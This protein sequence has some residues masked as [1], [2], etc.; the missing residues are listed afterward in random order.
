MVRAVT[1]LVVG[2]LVVSLVADV[3]SQLR[4]EGTLVSPT[5]DV[6]PDG[7]YWV[8]FAVYDSEDDSGRP[9]VVESQAVDLSGGSCC[10][11]LAA[12]ANGALDGGAYQV[13]PLQVLP[14]AEAAGGCSDAVSQDCAECRN[15]DMV[16]QRHAT[17]CGN[18]QPGYLYPLH[19]DRKFPNTVLRTGSGNRLDADT[20]DGIHASG[21]PR[22][23]RLY[24]LAG[25]RKFPNR[26]LRTGHD[27]GLDADLLDGLHASEIVN[28]AVPSGTIVMWSGTTIPDGWHRFTALD[29]LFP[30]GAATYGGTGG[31]ETHTHGYSG[32]TDVENLPLE[33]SDMRYYPGAEPHNAHTHGYSGTTGSASS[34]PP[35]L[36]IIFIQKD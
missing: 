4:Y 11:E 12:G 35:Y 2:L 13:V 3:S 14:A 1:L 28:Q 9:V 36:D 5:G 7:T 21:P 10:V 8:V 6:F 23:G 19:A 20:V 18:P 16:D 31:S 26:V 27:N 17:G 22:A 33:Y 30:R 24:P 34:L 29:G 15:A 32:N 25:D